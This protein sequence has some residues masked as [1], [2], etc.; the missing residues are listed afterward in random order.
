MK[1]K[2]LFIINPISG[3]IKKANLPNLI[4]K[5]LDKNQF[6]YTIKY[7]E[8]TGHATFLAKEAVLDSVDIIVAVGGDGSIN[9]ISQALVDTPVA[10]AVIPLGSGNGL[11]YH[12]NLPIRNPKKALEVINNSRIEKMDVGISNYSQFVSNAGI[13]LEA[14][15]ARIY[16]HHKT[17]GFL[18]YFMALN[19]AVLFKYRSKKNK[20]NFKIDGVERTENIYMFTVF[21]SAYFGYKMGFAPN[22]SLNDGYFDL[23]IVKGLPPYK[24]PILI[25][26]G[27]LK[28]VHL[29][30]ECEFHRVKH[31]EISAQRKRIAQIDG[32]SF[33]A[34]KNFTMSIK[35]KALNVVIP[36]ELK[37]I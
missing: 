19:K 2:V 11:A 13:G 5:V 7:S 14:V 8:H 10:L 23:V 1:R 17:R 25:V 33:V 37:S 16:R 9:E 26:L 36:R 12:L 20:V 4:D 29:L 21:N 22:A 3:D 32:D 35:E 15:T 30:K 18:S 31:I 34:S 27:I 28:K 6:D 24:I